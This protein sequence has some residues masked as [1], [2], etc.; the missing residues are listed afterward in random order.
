V[1]EFAAEL[2]ILLAAC[3]LSGFLGWYLRGL[4][5]NDTRADA[6]RS[7]SRRND[8]TPKPQGFG[9]FERVLTAGAAVGEFRAASTFA[10]TT[11]GGLASRRHLAD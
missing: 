10:P 4:T 6:S 1:T 8:A 5:R 9:T 2:T 3:A 11:P 7:W